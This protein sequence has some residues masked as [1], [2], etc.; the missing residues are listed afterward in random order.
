MPCV[1]WAEF[2]ACVA[3]TAWKALPLSWP[4]NSYLFFNLS[5]ILNFSRSHCWPHRPP[6]TQTQRCPPFPRYPWEC[7]K[8]DY[9]TYTC[10]VFP[11]T[12]TFSLEGSTLRLLCGMCELPA[13][14][15]SHPGP[16]L[17][18]RRAT[19]TQ[20][21]DA[22]TVDLMTETMTDAWERGEAGQRM[23]QVLGR[24]ERDGRRFHHTTQNDTQFT[25]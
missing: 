25:T 1:L 24:M 22:T 8:L 7:L 21:C 5:S 23:V 13:S 19:W 6:D 2:C 4:G 3:P 11:H 17:G 20:L 18:E 9:Q 16:L 12:Y 10:Y 15:L 14:L